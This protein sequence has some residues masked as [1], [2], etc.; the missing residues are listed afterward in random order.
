MI[1]H[2]Q[3]VAH[4]NLVDVVQSASFLPLASRISKYPPRGDDHFLN[5]CILLLTFAKGASANS[6]CAYRARSSD[7]MCPRPVIVPTRTLYV[8]LETA[9]KK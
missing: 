5:D 8:W 2:I 4:F 6:V 9:I 1:V 3:N 7:D